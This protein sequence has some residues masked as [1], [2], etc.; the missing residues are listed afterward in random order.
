ME[1]GF[2]HLDPP[3][4]IQIPVPK[5]TT[6]EVK[7]IKKLKDSDWSMTLVHNV[8]SSI[9]LR[10]LVSVLDY[11]VLRIGIVFLDIIDDI[12]PLDEPSTSLDTLVVLGRGI[13]LL[14]IVVVNHAVSV[15][16]V[17]FAGSPSIVASWTRIRLSRFGPGVAGSAVLGA[18]I[19]VVEAVVIVIVIVVVVV[20]VV[21]VAAAAVVNRHG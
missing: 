14:I 19:I 11:R 16:R 10:R 6:A 13:V 21:V 3:E 8:N 5:I 17:T 4:L 9:G 2:K 18:V 1:Y 15:T 12:E 7:D 20:V